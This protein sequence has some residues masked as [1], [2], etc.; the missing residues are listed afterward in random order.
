M[1]ASGNCCLIAPE[2]ARHTHYYLDP[3][4]LGR[5]CGRIPRADVYFTSKGRMRR[6]PRSPDRAWRVR[7]HPEQVRTKLASTTS[8]VYED[9]ENWRRVEW[10]HHQYA[11]FIQY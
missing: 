8:L 5:L 1:R 7:N 11:V 3:S 9:P 6:F 4:W 10:S 2:I